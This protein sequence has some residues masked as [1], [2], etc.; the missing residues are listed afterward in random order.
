MSKKMIDSFVQDL[1]AKLDETGIQY[2]K[3]KGSDIYVVGDT[4]LTFIRA[5]GFNAIYINST[6]FNINHKFDRVLC[7][8]ILKNGFSIVDDDGNNFEIKFDKEVE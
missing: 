6:R 5:I 2:R 4:T 1:L 8:E 3:I 7:Y